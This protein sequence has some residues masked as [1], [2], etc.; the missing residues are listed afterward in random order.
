MK[1]TTRECLIWLNGWLIGCEA[2]GHEKTS[3]LPKIRIHLAELNARPLPVPESL[4]A[5]QSPKAILGSSGGGLNVITYSDRKIQ[6]SVLVL[7]GKR[8]PTW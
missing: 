8:P 1:P 4:Q 7:V 3:P 2:I 6:D 5:V